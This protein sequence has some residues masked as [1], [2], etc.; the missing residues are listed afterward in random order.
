VD[1]AAR[2]HLQL[3]PAG[4]D[5]RVHISHLCKKFSIPAKSLAC[6]EFRAGRAVLLEKDP[7]AFDL[8]AAEGAE[9]I[10]DDAVHQLEVRRQ[11]RRVLLRVVEDLLAV[12]LRIHRRAR[13]AVDEDEL[14][15]EDEALPLL[16]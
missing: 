3:M 15:T 4:L 6:K 12:R 11:R 9:E 14:R 8:L 10:R 2:G 5:D 16:V 7:G 1:V 13:A